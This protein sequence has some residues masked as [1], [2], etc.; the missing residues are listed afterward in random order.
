[1]PGTIHVYQTM[2]PGTSGNEVSAVAK[3]IVR[4]K[5]EARSMA[6]R[7]YQYRCGVLAYGV[8]RGSTR[9]KKKDEWH[10]S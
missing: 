2:G 6:T 7:E 1:M 5:A 8:C 10:R 3:D 4:K 9:K